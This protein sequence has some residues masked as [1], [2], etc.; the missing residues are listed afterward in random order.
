MI[1]RRK[2]QISYLDLYTAIK[3][4]CEENNC[5]YPGDPV[6]ELILEVFNNQNIIF[7]TNSR[8]A[9]EQIRE[10]AYHQ[11][12]VA[13]NKEVKDKLSQYDNILTKNEL[14]VKE[15]EQLKNLI[16]Q[17]EIKNDQANELIKKL[18]KENNDLQQQPVNRVVEEQ[19]TDIVNNMEN[20][21]RLF[22]NYKE[23]IS[24]FKRSVNVFKYYSQF[25]NLITLLNKFNDYID[26]NHKSGNDKINEMCLKP[27]KVEL[28]SVIRGFGIEE[29]IPNY[30]DEYNGEYHQT[31]YPIN[32]STKI[33]ECKKPGYL[34]ENK[35]ISKA[36]VEVF[37]ER[38]VY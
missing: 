13:E 30:G 4:K 17:F 21:G 28:L 3:D 23:N 32:Y 9:Y 20:I 31:T 10:K 14:L 1:N 24:D 15:N 34:Y 5:S 6:T 27:L 11:D 36:E 35:V 16:T 29:Y 26:Y 7:A 37:E 8:H 38:E 25:E 18:K 12:I 2:S 22:I 33:K 19:Y